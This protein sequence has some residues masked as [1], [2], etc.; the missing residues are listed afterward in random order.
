M[1]NPTHTEI[2][3]SYANQWKLNGGAVFVRSALATEW[4]PCSPDPAGNWEYLLA[5]RV[6]FVWVAGPAGLCRLAPHSH[7]DGW[8]EPHSS[9]LPSAEITALSNSPDGLIMVGYATGD[10]VDVDID[11]EGKS[12]VRKRIAASSPV[13]ELDVDADGRIIVTTVTG[14]EVM[15]SD[16]DA[17]QRSWQELARLP[18]GNHDLFAIDVDGELWMAGGLTHGLGYPP[19]MHV[20][21]EVF[22]YNPSSDAWRVVDRMPFPRCY[23]G[24]AELEGDVWIV[25]GAANL[26]DP[27]NPRG[28]REPLDDVRVYSPSRERDGSDAWR[29]GPSLNHARLEPV[30]QGVNQRIWVIGGTDGDPMAHVESI[31]VDEEEWRVETP[32]PWVQ[33]QAGGCVLD[34]QVYCV[35][36]NGFLRL[37]P[38]T[39]Q[40]DADL[41]QLDPS[42]QAAQVAAYDGKVWVMGGSRRKDTHIFD[43]KTESWEVGPD[44]PTDNSWGAALDLGG[45]LVVAGGAHWSERHQRYYFDDRLIA[46][47]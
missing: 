26:G 18:G 32:L 4:Q 17:W 23:S 28:E 31:G 20:F 6:G 2:I 15:P 36:R 5:D 46:L 16:E 45:R 21:D 1:P 40:W 22:A 8:Q 43:P 47:R 9:D 41:L 39:G 38:E 14:R 24:I 35:S 44:L 25:G 29:A 27:D 34:G 3:D 33:N 13:R 42:P 19:Q 10:V 12:L 37:D 30:V 11:D 7:E